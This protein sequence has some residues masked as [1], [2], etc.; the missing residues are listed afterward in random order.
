[1][2]RGENVSKWHEIFKAG[3]YPQGDF[4]E[5]DLDQVVANYKPADHEAP[6]VIG[7]PKKD[8]PAF[9]WVDAVKREG[10]KLLARF[11]QVVPEFSE[12]VNQGRYKKVSVRLRKSEDGWNLMHVGFL[13]AAIPEVKGLKPVQF[14]EDDS[15]INF[16]IDF[17]EV[18]KVDVEQLREQIR[19]ELVVEFSADKTKLEQDLEKA[20]RKIKEAGFKSFIDEHKEKLPPAVRI[21]LVEFMSTLSEEVTVEFSEGEKD[22]KKEV[23]ASPLEFFK[24]FIAKLPDQVEFKEIAPGSQDKGGSANRKTKDFDYGMPVDEEAAQL[25]KKALDF[26]EKNKVSYEEAVLAIS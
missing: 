23:K 3:S 26:A 2:K 6:L 1:L 18:D 24:R 20:N 9:G 16:E 21:G 7:H 15:D 13:G 10:N 12:A 4:N 22:Q 14:S 19:K 11:K 17:K 5:S 25:H 8:D